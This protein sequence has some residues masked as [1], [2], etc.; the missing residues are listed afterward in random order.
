MTAPSELG[1]TRDV[2][3]RGETQHRH[4]RLEL[5]LAGKVSFGHARNHLALAHGVVHQMAVG[6]DLQCGE[7]DWKQLVT[8][9]QHS[10]HVRWNGELA[11]T[12][13]LPL[14]RYC[15]LR[16]AEVIRHRAACWR[17][18][19]VRCVQASGSLHFQP[20]GWSFCP[21][22]EQTQVPVPV[23]HTPS[24]LGAGSRCLPTGT[25]WSVAIIIMDLSAANADAGAEALAAAKRFAA[26]GIGDRALRM[27][28]KAEKLFSDPRALVDLRA[29]IESAA[30]SRRAQCTSS[31]ARSSAAPA[32]GTASGTIST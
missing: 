22:V 31:T 24:L 12:Q 26:S 2:K 7:M 30:E 15:A 21:L 16:I 5:F 18:C 3:V 25:W 29:D 28:S 32:S 1:P 17:R 10:R 11:L 8:R 9:W 4:D 13:R 6:E 14:R 19:L 27:L 23:G 20:F